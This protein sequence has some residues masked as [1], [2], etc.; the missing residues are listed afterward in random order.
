MALAVVNAQE[1]IR[2]DNS[3]LSAESWLP[4]YYRF[5]VR[6]NA[7]SQRPTGV[8][9]NRQRSNSCCRMLHCILWGVGSQAMAPQHRTM[10]TV[11][12]GTTV[13]VTLEGGRMLSCRRKSRIM[14]VP[15][16][17]DREPLPSPGQTENISGTK[18]FWTDSG[19]G[20][21]VRLGISLKVPRTGRGVPRP[22]RPPVQ[23][24]GRAQGGCF[25]RAPPTN[26]LHFTEEIHWEVVGPRRS[27]TNGWD[28]VAVLRQM[29][30]RV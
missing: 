13:R 8:Q 14:D 15:Q 3:S 21:V 23:R 10:H 16:S 22:V 26:P 25:A 19:P 12:P 24:T 28:S 5:S 4:A 9:K 11:A 18:V 17:L 29:S 7:H 20:T 30:A 27:Y 6:S 2:V 1:F